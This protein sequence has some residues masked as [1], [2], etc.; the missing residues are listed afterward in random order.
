MR[1][2]FEGEGVEMSTSVEDIQCPRCGLNH[3]GTCLD[4]VTDLWNEAESI[5]RERDLLREALAVSRAEADRWRKIC[6]DFHKG[7]RR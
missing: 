7:L 2:L 3:S 4:A 5:R 1:G 6:M